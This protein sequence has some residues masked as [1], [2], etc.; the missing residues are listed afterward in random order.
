MH[1]LISLVFSDPSI[2][3]K[4]IGNFLKEAKALGMSK[5]FSCEKMFME[6]SINN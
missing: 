1:N 6:N 4:S 3:N 5:Y 2:N